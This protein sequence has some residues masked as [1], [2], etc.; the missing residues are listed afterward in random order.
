M[1]SILVEN[2]ICK[3]LCSVLCSSKHNRCHFMLCTAS[4]FV[5]V[6]EYMP[7]GGCFY[8]NIKSAFMR[9]L[10]GPSKVEP[11]TSD[12]LVWCSKISKYVPC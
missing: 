1:F 8:P 4:E 10:C 3:Q 9:C 11:L 5:L 7:F 2:S 12:V 6:T